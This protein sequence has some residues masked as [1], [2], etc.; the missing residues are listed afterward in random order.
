MHLNLSSINKCIPNFSSMWRI[1]D[2][3]LIMMMNR[4]R[5]AVTFLAVLISLSSAALPYPVRQLDMRNGLSNNFIMAMAQDK[6]G[7]L[8]IATEDGLNRFDGYSFQSFRKNQNKN[9]G[10]AGNEL[11]CLLNDSRQGLL[12]IGTQRKGLDCYNYDTGTFSHF[13]HENSQATSLSD[14][15]VTGLALSK[16]GGIWIAT[17]SGGINYLS[18]GSKNFTHY[19]RKNVRGLRSD[20]FWNVLELS[21]GL[22]LAGQVD[23]GLC[24]IDTRKRTA[25]NFRHD[26]NRPSSIASNE[27]N[28]LYRDAAGRIWVGTSRGLDIFDITRGDFIHCQNN[29]LTNR[30]IFSVM[31]MPDGEIWVAAE[32]AGITILKNSGIADLSATVASGHISPG[33]APTGLVGNTVR[34]MA[35]DSF[36]NVFL[37]M[38]GEGLNFLSA[39]SPVFCQINYS[40]I[41]T[42]YTITNKSVLGVAVDSTGRIWAGTDGTGI[43]LLTPDDKR[44]TDFHLLDGKAVQAIYCTSK[45]D[46]L[47]G[48]FMGGSIVRKAKS[49]RSVPLFDID[50]EIDVRAFYE[51]KEGQIWIATSSGLFAAWPQQLGHQALYRHY[52][53]SSTSLTRSV[54]R[55]RLGRVWLGTFNGGIDV[56]SPNLKRICTLNL[57]NGLPSNTV[58]QLICD[59]K[60]RMW[61]ATSEGL[62][63]FEGIGSKQHRIYG[64]DQGLINTSVR[65]II[66]DKDHHI[67]VSTNS[68]IACLKNDEAQFENYDYHDNIPAGNFSAGCVAQS[69]DGILYFGSNNGLCH[70]NPRKVLADQQ[71]PPVRFLSIVIGRSDEETDTTIALLGRDHLRLRYGENTFR[72]IFN[73]KNPA[74][75]QQVEYQYRIKDD[76]RGWTL[77]DGNS[78][79]F[80]QLSPDDYE[81]E[82]RCRL[83]NRRWSVPSTFQLTV[84]PPLWLTWWAKL[85]YVLAILAVLWMIARYYWHHLR[86]K[87]LYKLEKQ[88]YEQEVELNNERSQFY[89]NIAHELRTPLTLVIGPLEE[90]TREKDIGRGPSKQINAVYKSAQRL[91]ELITK[92]LEFKKA[93]SSSR[94]LC[95]GRSNIVATLREMYIRYEELYQSSPVDFRFEPSEEV[96]N[97]YFDKDI[98]TVVLD[99]L[100]SNAVKYTPNGSITLAVKSEETDGE[101]WVCISVSDTG[102][103]IAPEDLPHVFE[104]FYQGHSHFQASGTGIGL[105]LVSSLVELHQGRIDVASTLGK[106]TTFTLRLRRDAT[107]EEALHLTQDSASEETTA[108]QQIEEKDTSTDNPQETQET[109]R[110][111]IL[112]VEDN[113]EIAQYIADCLSDRF[114]ISTAE[115]GRRGVEEAFRLIPDLIISD[116]MMPYMSGTDLCKVLKADLRTSHIPI[117]LLTAKDSMAAK[118][119]GYEAGADSYITKP[120]VKSLIES[121]VDNLL[122][123]RQRVRAALGNMKGNGAETKRQLLAASLSA[124]DQEFVNH[125]DSIIESHIGEESMDVSFLASEL[126]MSSSTLYRKMK[127]LSGLSPNEY[128]RKQKM[129]YAEKLLLEGRLSISEIGFKIGMSSTAYFRKCFKEEYGVSPSEYLRNIKG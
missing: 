16:K 20:R 53:P 92:L 55:D 124:L 58:N 121:R 75:S 35:V 110:P 116:V 118:Q 18:P 34:S 22:L 4:L 8:W 111:S 52:V 120:F 14:D 82:V 51:D 88:K 89:T 125:V 112:V 44:I 23:D 99:N 72:L 104:R 19:N 114:D 39:T 126:C 29:E 87:Y 57:S 15:G 85:I 12:W 42:P 62:V 13:H 36:G 81:V 97:M 106:G 47:I 2:R 24:L 73:V 113:T 61:A 21:D 11:N 33:L 41:P 128:I 71:C 76:F 93:E 68:G 67:W 6:W 94:R 129:R 65:A 107:Y 48:C 80:S 91:N 84:E 95:V 17:Y 122:L 49:N 38:Y 102:H 32:M 37:G 59:H 30:K 31:Q 10:L 74:L 1:E 3:A 28:C 115:N 119:E 27:V 117:I 90:L 127:S 43:N 79:S 7:C 45:G 66:E 40:P 96:I 9:L 25:R 105:S 103:G 50:Q 70:F 63:R 69:P 123:Q 108:Y 46:L 26:G 64:T 98:L 60:G 83:H 101:N 5:Y 77:L 86:L 78:L 109:G 54:C 56:L 100:M